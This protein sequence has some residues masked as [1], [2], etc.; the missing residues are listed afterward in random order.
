VFSERVIQDTRGFDRCRRPLQ[1][2]LLLRA[3]LLEIRVG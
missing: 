1:T 3:L 2:L